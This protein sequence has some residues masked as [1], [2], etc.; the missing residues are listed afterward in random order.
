MPLNLNNITMLDE[1]ML[2]AALNGDLTTVE[3]MVTQ[4][5]HMTTH[6]YRQK[7]SRVLFC[8]LAFVWS[9]ALSCKAESNQLLFTPAPG[10]PIAMPCGPG[11]IIAGDI[12][13]DGKS[14]IVAACGEKRTLNILMGRG[15]G[16][17]DVAAGSPIQLQNPPNEI[18]I[19]DMNGD[20]HPDL[21][22]ASHDS[23]DVLILPGD[24]NGGFSINEGY[25]VTM[26]KGSKPH[27]HGLGL[28]DVNGDQIPDIITANSNDNDISVMINSKTKD[29]IP[30]SGSPFPV[31][32]SPYPLTL[33]DL[34]QD[35]NLDIVSTS[36]NTKN[37]S[38]LF[39]AQGGNFRRTDI[40]LKTT[41]PWFVAVGDINKDKFPDLVITHSERRELTVLK[42]SG[43]GL[44]T[45]LPGSPYDLGSNAWHIALVDVNLDRI[46]DIIAAANNGV[47]VMLGDGR[48]NFEPASGSPFLTGRGT[49]HLAITDV[50]GDRKPDV[51]T[52]NLESNNISVLVGK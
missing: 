26:R 18:D 47:R 2:S 52:S 23:Y 45:E 29:F 24:G 50:N 16:E 27:T 21:I 37:L 1:R 4:G 32:T 31:S 30:S 35:G 48:G 40:T 42:G 36:T 34:N 19:R 43:N 13:H 12:N 39:G 6:K 11:N 14:D 8:T 3:E 44:F 15:N 33:G 5:K 9:F 25:S 51:V 10:S 28:G 22:I 41:G 7:N 20:T 38:V 17:Y 49:W 46:P